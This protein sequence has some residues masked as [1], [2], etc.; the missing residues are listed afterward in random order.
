M[1]KTS[2][3]RRP[4]EKPH[5]KRAQA[6]FKSVSHRLYQIHRSLSR[7]LSWKNSLLLKWQFL[8]L[9]DNTWA[10]DEKYPVLNRE[11]LT[12]PIQMQLS[13]KQT[14][15]SDFFAKFLKSRLNFKH[16]ESKGY[17]YRFSIFEVTESENVVT[18]ISK[19]FR[20]RR[21]FDKQNGK[22][23]QALFKFASHHLYQTQWS[24][25]SQLSWK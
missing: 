17:P 25:P 9:L 5:G 15:I 22:R 14:S 2:S 10:T 21:C 19:K 1:S 16:F 12:I 13:Q 6:R 8:G 23:A 3:F 4:F 7:Q 18:E 24:L 20:F 11:N